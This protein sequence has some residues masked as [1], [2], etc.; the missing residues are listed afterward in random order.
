MWENVMINK[1]MGFCIY[2]PNVDIEFIN[3][4]C[5]P[6]SCNCDAHFDSFFIV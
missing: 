1:L 2:F 3:F 5:F 4:K 6:D